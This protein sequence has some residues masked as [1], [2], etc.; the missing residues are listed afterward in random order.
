MLLRTCALMPVFWRAGQTL[1]KGRP[2]SNLVQSERSQR[3]RHPGNP[4]DHYLYL[5]QRPTIDSLFRIERDAP[6][7]EE[8]RVDVRAS[9][10]IVDVRITSSRGCTE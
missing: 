5:L 1:P 8:T 2:H 6:L 3:R 9:V 10:P 4:A 7:A